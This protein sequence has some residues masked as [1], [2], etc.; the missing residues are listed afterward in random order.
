MRQELVDLYD[1]CNKQ[2]KVIEKIEVNTILKICLQSRLF[3]M[4]LTLEA[5]GHSISLQR[6]NLSLQQES[7]TQSNQ[8]TYTFASLTLFYSLYKYLDRVKMSATAKKFEKE[9]KPE[10]VNLTRKSG[11]LKKSLG[12]ISSNPLVWT[13]YVIITNLHRI[14]RR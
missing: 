13:F 4:E 2:A 11:D 8:Y 5:S 6:I 1:I 12:P 9:E 14:P 3:R 7:N 10:E